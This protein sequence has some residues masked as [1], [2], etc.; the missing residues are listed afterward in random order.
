[1]QGPA[2]EG[3]GSTAIKPCFNP[4]KTRPALFLRLNTAMIWC[5]VEFRRLLAQVEDRGNL[6]HGPALGKRLHNVA[7]TFGQVR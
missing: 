5:L 2:P 3:P 7:L 6:F 4:N 1:M